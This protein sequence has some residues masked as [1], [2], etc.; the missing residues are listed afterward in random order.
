MFVN[1][2]WFGVIITILAE[3]VLFFI[4]SIIGGLKK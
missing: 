4:F 2:F 3:F 1:P